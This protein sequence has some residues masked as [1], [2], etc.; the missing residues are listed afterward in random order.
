[1]RVIGGL[2]L[3]ASSALLAAAAFGPLHL[4]WLVFVAFVPMIVAQH[5]VLPERWS[6]LALAV[7]I[8]G[9]ITG[10]LV[11]LLDP[12]FAWWMRVISAA[13]A[14]PL[15]FAGRADRSFH[16]N[17]ARRWFLVA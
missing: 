14:I 12:S 15:A 7:G 2:A 9:Y 5:H 11:P 6:G 16:T 8:G 10:Y 4:W 13:V 3:S 17:T 1:M